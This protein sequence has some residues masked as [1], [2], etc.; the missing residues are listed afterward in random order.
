MSHNLLLVD[1]EPNV[2]ASLSRNLRH[3]PYKIFTATNAAE[4]IDCL[5]ANPIDLMVAD[6]RMPGMPGSELAAWAAA[7]FPQVMRIMLSGQAS[8]PATLRAINQGRIYRFL[9]KPVSAAEL[10]STIEAA[11]AERDRRLAGEQALENA[12]D[13]EATLQRERA[14]VDARQS[15]L[16]RKEKSLR[17]RNSRRMQWFATVTHELRSPLT[18]LLGS[19]D[20]LSAAQSNDERGKWT[21]ILQRSGGHLLHLVN[22]TLDHAKLAAG[23]LVCEKGLCAPREMVADVMAMFVG[24]AQQKGLILAAKV[25]RRVPDRVVTDP[26]RLKQIVI[27]LVS[28]AIKFTEFG[29]VELH[30]SW[31][32]QPAPRLRCEVTDTGSGM[33]HDEIRKVFRRYAQGEAGRNR[34]GTGLGLA[35]SRQMARLLGGELSVTSE[36]GI[37]SSFVVNVSAP[38]ANQAQEG[39]PGSNQLQRDGSQR[40]GS[41]RNGSQRGGR[42][43]VADDSPDLRRII[44]VF[45]THAGYETT[46]VEN[47]EQ[48][49]QAV[50]QAA[51]AKSPFD[52]VLLDLDMP[53]LD[54]K[55]AARRIR[56][57]GF[58][59]PIVAISASL[60]S[61]VDGLE[62]AN[63]SVEDEAGFDAYLAKPIARGE[64]L[65][66]LRLL[67]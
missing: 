62:P 19:V 8:L 28:N 56:Q 47:G 33:T 21:E 24:N 44:D 36:P 61:T 65:E 13:H 22:Q 40:N 5:T 49:A 38:Q 7:R 43:L 2:L 11:L 52:L 53:V 25:D 23:K 50:E 35:H 54:G 26:L 3:L 18:A 16:A 12:A 64:F 29:R 48:A 27:N 41:Q 9:T 39:E 42:I 10:A 20:L 51:S 55:G 58:A 45:L 17:R 30:V 34:G 59:G 32:R 57:A 63:P 4:A 66:R 14:A 67:T 37:G 15:E 46:L 31:T 1:D 60:A 6:E